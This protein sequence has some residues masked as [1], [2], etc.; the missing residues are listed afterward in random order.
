MYP[1]N[2][3]QPCEL[4][5]WEW[6]A[7]CAACSTHYLTT[8]PAFLFIPEFSMN[9]RMYVYGLAGWPSVMASPLSC[10]GVMVC[11]NRPLIIPD[12]PYCLFTYDPPASSLRTYLARQTATINDTRELRTSS[13]TPCEWPEKRQRHQPASSSR[14]LDPYSC[15]IHLTFVYRFWFSVFRPLILM[16]M[17]KKTQLQLTTEL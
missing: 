6:V 9:P 15:L 17:K 11:S 14:S 7:K 3:P 2:R 5:V 10:C 16:H 12:R 1:S 13:S 8:S 4:E